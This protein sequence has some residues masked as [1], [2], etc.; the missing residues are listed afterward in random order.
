MDVHCR[1]RW[2]GTCSGLRLRCCVHGHVLNHTVPSFLRGLG[3]IQG[4]DPALE[5]VLESQAG[6]RQER[7]R[8]WRWEER[9]RRCQRRD[10]ESK[11]GVPRVPQ[12]ALGHSAGHRVADP[13]QVRLP[14]ALR[15]GARVVVQGRLAVRRQLGQGRARRARAGDGARVPHRGVAV[16]AAAGAQGRLPAVARRGQGLLRLRPGPRLL[17]QG[18]RRRRPHQGRPRRGR[19]ARTRRGRARVGRGGAVRRAHLRDGLPQVVR[20]PPRR[21]SGRARR[22]D[23]RAV[24]L[25]PR[26]PAR[27]GGP[28]VCGERGRDH[29]Q[30]RDARHPGRV[31]RRRAHGP[32]AAA[33]AGGDGG[34]GGGC[35]GVE[36]V[37]DAGDGE[38]GGPG[39]AAPDPLPRPP[40]PGH[41]SP[42]P[43]QGR[44]RPGRAPRPLPPPRL[45]R[46]RRAPRRPRPLSAHAPCQPPP[47]PLRRACSRECCRRRRRAAGRGV[48]CRTRR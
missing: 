16:R 13:V 38:P 45:R 1:E 39:A 35:Q 23:G 5:P 11:V 10:R 33:A 26:D 7:N 44:Q 30:H 43:P 24:P 40:P 8:G 37:L 12:R 31:A 48:R 15:A 3:V 28:G 22:A 36:A 32:R 20:L 42:P 29:L 27:G 4:G 25:P 6:R 2:Q 17:L 9:S 18:Q 34:G 46:R 47:P 14:L 41:G 19:P 21:D